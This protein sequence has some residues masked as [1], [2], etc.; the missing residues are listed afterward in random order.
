MISL[1][2]LIKLHLIPIL[3]SSMTRF[4]FPILYLIISVLDIGFGQFFPEG[5]WLSKPLLMLVLALYF[6]Q[7]TKEI[8]S[9]RKLFFFAALFFAWLGDVFLL[10]KGAFYFQLGL[11]AFLVMQLIYCY[12]FKPKNGVLN[13]I[14]VKPSSRSMAELVIFVLIIAFRIIPILKGAGAMAL[15]VIIYF[16]AISRMV[17]MAKFKDYKTF[18]RGQDVIY[19]GAVFFFFSDFF[20]AHNAFVAKDNL[21]Q[22]LVMPTYVFAQFCITYGMI[23]DV[24]ANSIVEQKSN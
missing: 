14:L 22:F 12:L 3:Y 17:L 4:L 9:N 23:D 10:F 5:R 11:G 16:L 21:F 20:I 7:E 13:K 1:S 15:P 24:K 8:Q 6:W 18:F 2:F 19:L